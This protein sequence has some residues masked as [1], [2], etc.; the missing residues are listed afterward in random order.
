M[1]WRTRA[2][3]ALTR[4]AGGRVA[5]RYSISGQMTVAIGSCTSAV[6]AANGALAAD[7]RARGAPV[8]LFQWPGGAWLGR[9]RYSDTAARCRKCDDVVNTR[10]RVERV[11]ETAVCQ[12]ASFDSATPRG[13]SAK[14]RA[15]IRK[16][17]TLTFRRVAAARTRRLPDGT[18]FPGLAGSNGSNA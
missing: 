16:A 14:T 5:D 2:A 11:G 6:P 18:V 15:S 17:F 7:T 8:R 10:T 4:T 1:R 13:P 3:P 12:R 9:P